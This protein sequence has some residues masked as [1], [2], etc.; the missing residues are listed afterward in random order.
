MAH[1]IN[2]SGSKTE[3][4]WLLNF[5]IFTKRKNLLNAYEKKTSNSK[6]TKYKTLIVIG[7]TTDIFKKEDLF[8]FNNINTFVVFYLINEELNKVYMNCSWIFPLGLNYNKYVKKI[9]EII[10]E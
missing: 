8:Y 7:E 10:N 1:F 3:Y 9:N 6:F 2:T 4:R 5:V